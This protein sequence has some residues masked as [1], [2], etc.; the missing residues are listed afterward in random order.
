PAVSIVAKIHMIERTVEAYVL[1]YPARPGI[2][3]EKNRPGVADNPAAFVAH[4][5]NMY[6]LNVTRRPL[7]APG[8]AAVVS[9]NKDAVDD[10]LL[11]A[12]R[13]DHPAFLLAREAHAVQLD[14]GAFELFRSENSRLRPTRA[15]ASDKDRIACQEKACFLVTKVDVVYAGLGADVLAYP[16]LAAIRGIAQV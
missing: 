14:I 3:C 13:S 8:R 2:S 12:D 16:R 1:L 11:L 7:P 9:V 4:K 6:Q 15:V 10:A 5:I